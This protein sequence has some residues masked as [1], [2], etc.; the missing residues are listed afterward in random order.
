MERDLKTDSNHLRLA[1]D[2]K[3]AWA[4]VLGCGNP[5]FGDDGAGPA[6]IEALSRLDLPPG[7]ELQEAGTGVR[8]L[9]FDYLLS[10]LQRPRVMILVDSVT[11]PGKIPGEVFEIDV[12]QTPVRDVST[13]SLHQWP[14]LDML[15]ELAAEA[16]LEVRIIAIQSTDIPDQVRPGLSLQ[17]KEAVQRA[18]LLVQQ[19]LKERAA[20]PLEA[21]VQ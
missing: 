6:V 19:I 21:T 12:V 2:D 16:S 15:R 17:A 4:L 3:G 18:A 1:S 10:P 5:L 7:I 13:I 20:A 8:E 14:T 9:L 11:I